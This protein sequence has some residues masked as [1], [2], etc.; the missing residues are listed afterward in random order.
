MKFYI[1]ILILV[2][3]IVNIQFA[4]SQETNKRVAA[5]IEVQKNTELINVQGT[6]LNKTDLIMSLRFDMFV[7]RTNPKNG[8][9][10]KEE[11]SARIV[12]QPSEKRAL[13]EINFNQNQKD[14]ITVVILIYD[15]ENKLLGKDRLVVLNDDKKTPE[16][17][18]EKLTTEDDIEGIRGIVIENTK[19]K[20]GRDFYIEFYSNY[21]LKG[22]NGPEV[23]KI[24]EQFSFGRSTIMEVSVGGTIV[25]KFFVQPRMDFIKAQSQAAIVNVTRY[26][27]NLERQRSY[28]KKY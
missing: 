5:K 27:L 22:I 26:F 17:K 1:Q 8:N 28:K 2:C 15:K 12:L 10:I 16:N 7:Y 9:V 4:S 23:V 24:T 21:R 14:K 18:T 25:H 19:T 13:A 11:K 20:P 6:A 3:T